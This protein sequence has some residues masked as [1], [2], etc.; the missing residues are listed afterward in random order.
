MIDVDEF[1][2]CPEIRGIFPPL[3]G[4]QKRRPV[5]KRGSVR[6][7]NKGESAADD[8]YI[9]DSSAAKNLTPAFP[10]SSPEKKFFLPFCKKKGAPYRVG[11]VRGCNKGES[12]TNDVCRSI[13]CYR[14]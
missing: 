8:V 6:G 14:L 7:C 4:E 1:E 2:S 12:I 11:P 10:E 3:C 9:G 5:P 13:A